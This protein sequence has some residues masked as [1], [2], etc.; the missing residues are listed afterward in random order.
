MNG[1]FNLSYSLGWQSPM[2]FQFMFFP[3]VLAVS[4]SVHVGQC[5]KLTNAQDIFVA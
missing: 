2:R 3:A 5:S 1:D 4:A